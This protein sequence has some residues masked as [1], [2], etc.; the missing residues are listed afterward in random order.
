MKHTAAII[1][2][3]NLKVSCYLQKSRKPWLAFFCLQFSTKFPAKSMQ[4]NT[5]ETST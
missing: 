1:K 4:P 5:L 3:P 2:E